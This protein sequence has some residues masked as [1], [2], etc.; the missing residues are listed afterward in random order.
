MSK[1]NN[2]SC[3]ASGGIYGV[4]MLGALVYFFQHAATFSEYIFGFLKALLW[5]GFIVYQLFDFLN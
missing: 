2:M 1:N 4:G 3:G 5:P